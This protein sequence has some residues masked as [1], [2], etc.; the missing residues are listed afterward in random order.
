MIRLS[1]LTDYGIVLMAYMAAHR[2]SVVTA[3]ELSERSQLPLPTVSK[4]LKL[5]SKG[6][7]IESHRG[8]NGGYQ[9]VR[10]PDQINVTEMIDALEGTIGMTRC[11]VVEEKLCQIDEHC[12]VKSPWQKI[13][14][15]VRGALSQ[16]TLTDMSQSVAI[17]KSRSLK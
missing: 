12:P 15:V 17:N 3:R 5:L 2:E 7:L 16:L 11:S 10:A 4:V 13:N 6:Q 14:T 1:R 8:V 9:L